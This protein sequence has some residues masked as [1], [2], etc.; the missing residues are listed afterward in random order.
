ME[1]RKKGGYLAEINSKTENTF[2]KEQAT[3]I[4]GNSSQICLIFVYVHEA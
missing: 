3:L 2:I 4:G 1:C